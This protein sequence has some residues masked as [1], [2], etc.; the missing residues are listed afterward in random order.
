MATVVAEGTPRTIPNRAR[1]KGSRRR[2]VHRYSVVLL[3]LSPWL[4]GFLAFTAY[5]MLSSLFFSFTRYD[6]LGEPVPVGLANYRF[7]LHDPLFW[8]A[9]KNTL[10][11]IVFVVPL[12][13]LV[14]MFTA[15]LLTRPKRGMR[16]Y[17]TAI[18]LPYMAPAVAAALAFVYLFNP[19]IGPV[20]QILQSVGWKDPPLWF[21]SPT[22]S[23]PGL[24]LLALWGGGDAMIIF[25]AGLLDVPKQ[26]YEAADIEGAR[27]WQRFRFITLPMI[28]PVIFF[29][30]V[31]GIIDGFQYFTQAYVASLATSGLD[32]A[33]ASGLG[34]PQYSLLFYSV[35]LYAQGFR[36]FHMGL[37]SAMAWILFAITLVCTLLIIRWSRRWVHYQGGMFR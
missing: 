25:L 27:P 34:N 30:L 24:R 5:P 3:F 33:G 7:L 31:I 15:M 29:S 10:W 21:F 2:T 4:I 23:K 14:A 16:V 18:F 36:Y 8:Q 32:S 22:W 20:N 26:L 1:R 37:A 19:R 28:S 17:R 12:R 6:L 35:Y 13:I 11:I 9:M